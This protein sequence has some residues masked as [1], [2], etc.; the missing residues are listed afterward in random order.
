MNVEE[1]IERAREAILKGEKRFGEYFIYTAKIDL[2]EKLSWE[3][4]KTKSYVWTSEIDQWNTTRR[5]IMESLG[6]VV[7]D[8]NTTE[9]ERGQH[10]IIN[11]LS[12]SNIDD[13]YKNFL[14]LILGDDITRYKINKNRIERG[15]PFDTAN[16][17]FS[18]ILKRYPHESDSKIKVALERI[19]GDIK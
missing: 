2:D 6:L 8:I 19:L 16:I 17:L 15:I 10:T 12:K 13:K 5:T 9:T 7:I 1:L 11:Y 4:I 14:Q 18:K 3:Y